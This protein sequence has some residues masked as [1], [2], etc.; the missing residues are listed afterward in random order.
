MEEFKLRLEYRL[1]STTMSKWQD[2]LLEHGKFPF[3]QYD[4]HGSIGTTDISQIELGC[5][6]REWKADHA[7]RD[8]ALVQKLCQSLK[9]ILGEAFL[10]AGADG[11]LLPNFSPRIQVD[12]RGHR[13][14]TWDMN[15]N[16]AHVSFPS[17]SSFKAKQFVLILA[18]ESVVVYQRSL[19]S[20]TQVLGG[21]WW[22]SLYGQ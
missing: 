18:T 16:E 19:R 12:E 4:E 9:D 20:R 15:L 6:K 8:D 7:V 1:I 3:P 2:F 10:P 22:I 17:M 14:E 11:Y 13:D 5:L 21:I